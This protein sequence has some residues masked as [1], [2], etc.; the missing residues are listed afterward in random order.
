MNAHQVQPS[1]VEYRT[2]EEAAARCFVQQL[3]AQL[4]HFRQVEI[5][6]FHL[7]IIHPLKTRNQ[8]TADVDDHRFRVAG[9]KILRPAIEFPQAHDGGR[10]IMPIKL[11]S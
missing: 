7:A 2:T 10:L 6:P 8:T 9:Q 5:V 1:S 3:M 4:Y 11:E